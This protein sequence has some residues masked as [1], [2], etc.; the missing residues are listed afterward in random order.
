MSR[1]PKW[2]RMGKG[3]VREVVRKRA[4]FLSRDLFPAFSVPR[5]GLSVPECTNY[6]FL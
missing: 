6:P 5:E 1:D 4:E 3:K 2:I